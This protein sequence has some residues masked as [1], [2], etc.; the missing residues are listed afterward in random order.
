[1][2]N[3][4]TTSIG[5]ISQQPPSDG[6]AGDLWLNID[7]DNKGKL[8]VHDGYEW[9]EIG[10]QYNE[11]PTTIPVAKEEADSPEEAYRRAMKILG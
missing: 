4:I 3:K 1:M 11:S 8:F 6:H 5:T 7:E 2:L 10:A 9:V